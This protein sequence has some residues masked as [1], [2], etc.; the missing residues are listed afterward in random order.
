M[1]KILKA[2]GAS[3]WSTLRKELHAV[4]NYSSFG[5]RLFRDSLG[6][7]AEEA[8]AAALVSSMESFKTIAEPSKSDCAKAKSEVMKTIWAIPGINHVQDKRQVTVE[9]RGIELKCDTHSI[10]G[11]V[12]LFFAA[13]MRGKA[14]ELGTL[15]PLPGEADMFESETASA[16][17]SKSMGDAHTLRT[18]M[19]TIV[20]SMK[21]PLN[22]EVIE[23][24]VET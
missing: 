19:A 24:R 12:D 13:Y 8:I 9:Y 21:P 1:S 16:G 4:C 20:G 3:K 10:E 18:L 6:V 23:D 17:V 5:S 11:Q 22:A 7:L 14:T 2:G 15:I